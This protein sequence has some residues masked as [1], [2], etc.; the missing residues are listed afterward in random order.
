MS[1]LSY[2]TNLLTEGVHYTVGTHDGREFKR[3]IFN[4]WELMNGKRIMTFRTIE[5]R[6]LTI[7]PSFHT[8][9]LEENS[10]ITKE[11]DN[12][13]LE[14]LGFKSL[15]GDPIKTTF[16]DAVDAGEEV[17]YNTKETKDG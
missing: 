13:A 16:Q 7:N 9:I 5:N 8:F 4:G 1:S 2:D 6:H 10:E 3:V 15:E 12:Q 14:E 17:E 11:E